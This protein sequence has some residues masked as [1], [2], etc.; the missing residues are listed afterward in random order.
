[1]QNDRFCFL[2]TYD[3]IIEDQN[4]NR[5]PDVV[6]SAASNEYLF[7]ECKSAI[8]Y[9]LQPIVR[10]CDGGVGPNVGT[11]NNNTTAPLSSCVEDGHDLDSHTAPLTAS[12]RN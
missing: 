9:K 12:V 1:L 8:Y 5:Y 10:H 11:S 3:V 4:D 6:L 2:V 7:M